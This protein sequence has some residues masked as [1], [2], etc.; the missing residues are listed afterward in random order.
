MSS[1]PAIR[2]PDKRLPE[3][4]RQTLEVIDASLAD[5]PASG[6]S[7]CTEGVEAIRDAFL[8]FRDSLIKIARERGFHIPTAVERSTLVPASGSLQ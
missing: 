5:L 2:R 1:H 7:Q 6:S 4:A 3:L 8:K